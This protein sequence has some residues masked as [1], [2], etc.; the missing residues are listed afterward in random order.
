MALDEPNADD[1]V[2]EVGACKFVMA[3]DVAQL[4]AQY[5]GVK[6]DFVDQP[7]R[8]GYVIDLGSRGG[9]C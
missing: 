7:H 8:R 2:V 4:V 6:I 5:G 3:P 1:K 9:C